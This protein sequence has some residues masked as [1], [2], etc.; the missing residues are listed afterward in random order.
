MAT[1][2]VDV[3]VWGDQFTLGFAP[4]DEVHAEFV[5]VVS[6]L[7]LATESEMPALL[8]AVAE[9]AQRH[10][11]AENRW[12]ED[13]NFPPRACHVEEHDK[14][15]ASILDVCVEVAAGDLSSVRPLAEA[16]A[17]W[18]PGHADY[19]DSALAQWLCKQRLGGKPVVLKR[20]LARQSLPPAT[21]TNG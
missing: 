18:F 11:D 13:S 3:L 15:L 21:G 17:D 4:M 20:A 2:S 16:L 8:E 19:L 1:D 14:V 12:M 10:F 6:R 7:Q 5:A 9:H